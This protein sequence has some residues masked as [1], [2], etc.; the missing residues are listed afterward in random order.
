M[1]VVAVGLAGVE[2]R[3]DLRMVEPG[4]ESRLLE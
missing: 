3:H 2:H 4:R 1:K